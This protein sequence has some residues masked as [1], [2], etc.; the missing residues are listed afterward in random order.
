MFAVPEIA[1]PRLNVALALPFLAETE[2]V[3]VP[4]VVVKLIGVLSG[5]WP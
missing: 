5:I 3:T 4:N 2:L 1:V